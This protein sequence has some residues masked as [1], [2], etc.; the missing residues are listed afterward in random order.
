MIVSL[1]G[2][3]RDNPEFYAELEERISEVGFENLIIGG[4]W[5]LVLDFTLD[6]YNDKHFNNAK[7]QEQVENLMINLDLLDIWRE[8]HPEMR[9]YT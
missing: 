2:P 5:N 9:R 3:N 1:Y 4:D 6:Y 8:I 7:A